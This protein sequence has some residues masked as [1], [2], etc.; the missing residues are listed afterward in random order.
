VD[1]EVKE[2]WEK[3]GE[4][5]KKFTRKFKY[6]QRKVERKLREKSLEN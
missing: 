2:N 3:T 6:N 5:P 4:N 1:D